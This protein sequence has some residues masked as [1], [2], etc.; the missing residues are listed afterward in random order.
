MGERVQLSL[1]EDVREQIRQ[2][3][4]NQALM[5]YGIQNEVSDFRTHVTGAMYTYIFPTANAKSLT[6]RAEHVGLKKVSV[7]TRGIETAQG[8]PVPI[9]WIEGLQEILIPQQIWDRFRIHDKMDTSKKGMLATSIVVE[10]LKNDM[11]P[12][13]VR[14][15][16]ADSKA[17]QVSGTD[18]LI[19][20]SLR[21]QVKCDLP[22]GQKRYG[23]TG[24]LF[25][26][27]AECNPWKRY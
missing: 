12:L 16:H 9:S 13:P 19:N 8:Y 5:D 18:I 24:N 1:F 15:N 14:L 26:Q 3:T 10:L 21:L 23:G 20:A 17:F 7:F 11:V 6:A 27:T 2:P 4:G 22:G 25:I